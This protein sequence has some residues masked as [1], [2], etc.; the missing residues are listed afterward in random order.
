MLLD[1][2]LTFHMP[3]SVQVLQS[4]F[5]QVELAVHAA[6]GS[7]NDGNHDTDGLGLDIWEAV[8]LAYGQE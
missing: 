3:Y 5:M 7:S 2:Y 8:K 4:L 6:R 1:Y